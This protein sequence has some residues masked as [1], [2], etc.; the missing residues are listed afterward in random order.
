MSIFIYYHD[1]FAE[2]GDVGFE[3]KNDI[4]EA[5]RFINDRMAMSEKPN[6]ENY[7]VVEGRALV[8]EPVEVVREI[9]IKRK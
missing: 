4:E 5:T 8:L 7:T 9:T 3:V 2:N 6:I 1:G